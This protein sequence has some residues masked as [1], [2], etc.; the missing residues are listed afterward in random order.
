[1]PNNTEVAKFSTPY[2]SLNTANFDF[3]KTV[4]ERHSF[5]RNALFDSFGAEIASLKNKSFKVPG[6]I[7]FCAI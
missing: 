4:K 7:V 3:K 5:S 2:R 6:E 1:M